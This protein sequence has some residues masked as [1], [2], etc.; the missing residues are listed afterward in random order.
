MEEKGKNLEY[1]SLLSVISAFSVVSLHTNGCFWQFSTERYWVTA[2]I[3]ECFY[4]FAVPIFFMIS[5]ATLMDYPKRYDTK[6]YFRKRISKT[7]IPFLVWSLVGWGTILFDAWR[8]GRDP[9]P[10]IL[11]VTGIWNG[12]WGTNFVGIYWFFIPLFICY[13]CIPLFAAVP[14]EK[15]KR[16]FGYLIV[17]SFVLQSLFPFLSKVGELSLRAPFHMDVAGGYLFYVL[18]GYW[19]STYETTKKYRRILYALAIAGLAAHIVGTYELSMEAGKI[20]KTYKGYLNV[21][22]IL[23]SAGVFVFFKENSD[24]ILRNGGGRKILLLRDYTFAIYI[25]HWFVM[26][27]WIAAMHW[28]T[29]SILWRLGGPILVGA[30]CIG[31]TYGMRKIPVVRS[32]LP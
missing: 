8:A 5:G 21:P 19:L 30:I 29:H 4:Y 7:L 1:I 14:A 18:L 2:N 12:I 31:I 6:M 26:R 20:I 13:L 24:T 27:Y 25:L 23:Y 15:R 11:T 3:I 22:C 10:D 17:G 32:I 28:N 9:N 16:L